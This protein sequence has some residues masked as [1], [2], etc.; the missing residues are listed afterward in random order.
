MEDLMFG[1]K[2]AV[3][4]MTV[5]FSILFGLEIM[6]RLIARVWG[7]KQEPLDEKEGET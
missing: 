1:I 2:L 5:V 4:G 3:I 7:P 6:V